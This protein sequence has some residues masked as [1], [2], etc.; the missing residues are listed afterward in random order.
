MFFVAWQHDAFHV[1]VERVAYP[2]INVI[3]VSLW[4]VVVKP[5]LNFIEMHL[6]RF[7]Q[8]IFGRG[9]QLLCFLASV[10]KHV[11]SVFG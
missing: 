6:D 2:G 1:D 11:Q 9:V 8:V 3:S 10:W 7:F 4:E 5:S